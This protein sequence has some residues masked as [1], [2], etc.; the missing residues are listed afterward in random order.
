[1]Y[2]TT[3]PA[4]MPVASANSRFMGLLRISFRC[5]A[6]IRSAAIT[7]RKHIVQAA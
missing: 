4:A 1:M 5:V 6:S 2:I 3:A 7:L